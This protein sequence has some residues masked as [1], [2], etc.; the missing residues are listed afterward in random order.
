MAFSRIIYIAFTALFLFVSSLLAQSTEQEAES[1]L[2]TEKS[3]SIDP[4]R[5]FIDGMR[6]FINNDYDKAL[7]FFEKALKKSKEKGS[8]AFQMSLCYENLGNRKKALEFALRA[9]ESDKKNTHY[10][11]AL[12]HKYRDAGD[13]SNAERLFAKL[14]QENPKDI[15][16]YN[17]MYLYYMGSMNY[18]GALSVLEKCEK[19]L[20]LDADLSRRKLLIYRDQGNFK[21]AIAEGEKLVAKYPYDEEIV[22]T[23]A[24]L[25]IRRGQLDAA[26]K[27]LKK[28]LDVS[29][30]GRVNA[31]LYLAQIYERKGEENKYF[32][33]IGEVLGESDA[34][35]APKI[36]ILLNLQSQAARSEESLKRTKVLA[37]KALNAHPEDFHLNV[38]A[39]DLMMMT[40]EF[41]K[42]AELYEK[43]LKDDPNNLL[44]WLRLIQIQFNLDKNEKAAKFTEEALEMFP[45]SP[46]L[47]H[48]Q[49][50]NLH[51]KKEYE[52]AVAALLKAK[53]LTQNND[54][55]MSEIEAHLGDLYHEL[56][57]HDK[58]DKAYENAIAL[59]SNNVRALNNYAYYLSVRKTK[60]PVALKLSSKLIALEPNEPTYLDTHG[61]VL[62]MNGD[63]KQAHEYLSKA[64]ANSTSSTI[65]EH[66]GDVL[67]KLGKKE[68]AVEQWKK[69]KSLGAGGL[70]DKKISLEQYIEQ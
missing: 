45:F 16:F 25:L 53:N 48:M 14:M 5:Y 28:Y 13:A 30:E 39:A 63:Y 18:D 66:Y 31:N 11:L 7:P 10:A 33:A 19:N 56:K 3:E 42:A 70:I 69:A 41:E 68:E 24:D 34:E 22:I 27:I 6:C 59:N 21:A 20:G 54:A 9:H 17:E 15:Q 43:S 29:D 55:L 67:Y 65:I 2:D 37:E 49:A 12:A 23:Q 38:I 1:V 60:L 50:T 35:V 4:E 64:A 44:V 40:N 52:E 61:W 26:E 46:E 32:D 57:N 36:N 62:F 51:L 47:W 58:S 8:I